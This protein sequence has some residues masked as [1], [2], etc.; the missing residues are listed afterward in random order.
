MT[1]LMPLPSF[2]VD[3]TEAAIPWKQLTAA[4]HTFTFATPDGRPAQADPIMLT[5]R[6]LGPLKGLLMAR[7]DAVNAYHAMR[8]DPAWSSPQTYAD[9]DSID[10]GELDGVVL[11]GGH[12]PGMK[13]YLEAQEVQRLVG[14]A[15]A[16]ELPV[17]AICHGVIVM[18][19]S[20]HPDSGRSVLH[21]RTTTALLQQQEMAAW[22]LT[23]AWLGDYYRTYPE[24]VQ[25]EVTQALAKTDDF[26]EGPRPI[27]R[28][29]ANTPGFH[30]RDGSYVSARWPGDVYG[31]SA[32]M[33]EMCAAGRRRDG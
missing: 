28:D 21:G 17:G 15:V 2:D 9:L 30:V 10:V 26:R 16:A 12:A 22:W 31:F 1:I 33:V 3:P 18:A 23:R 7:R 27:L 11:P 32:A 19:R 5:G 14:R 13:V 29:T 25:A 8:Q 4:G 20:R 24:S 6:G